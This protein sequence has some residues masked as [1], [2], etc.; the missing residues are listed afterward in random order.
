MSHK[1]SQSGVETPTLKVVDCPECG[2]E[3]EFFSND[4]KVACDKCGALVT[5]EMV[6]NELNK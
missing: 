2:N 3:L 6:Q 4:K 5:R 1:C